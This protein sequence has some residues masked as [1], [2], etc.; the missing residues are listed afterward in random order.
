VSDLINV[1]WAPVYNSEVDMQIS[2]MEP[3]N[4][5]NELLIDRNRNNPTGGF[6][7]CP[8]TTSILD[9]TFVW[10]TPSSSMADF[11]VIDGEVLMKNNDNY[12]NAFSWYI[13]HEPTLTDNLLVKF[14]YNIIFFADDDVEVLYTAP[15]FSYAPHTQYGVVVPGKFNVGS[16]FRPFNI[17]MNLWRGVRHVEIKENE[18]LAYFTFITDKKIR[19]QEFR[20]TE[21]LDSLAKATIQSTQWF[22]KRSLADRYRMFRA[23]KL[24][25]VVLEDIKN[26]LVR[27]ES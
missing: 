2:T 27:G 17:E 12:N 14:T 23:R 10:K 22:N 8:A 24:K 18:P 25:G 6:F 16:W 15:Y 5:R 26:N 4:L 1:Y 9:H 19:L 7:R 21:K 11:K 13:N 20:M 3:L